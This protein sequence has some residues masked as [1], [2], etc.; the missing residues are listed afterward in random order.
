VSGGAR[1]RAFEKALSFL[2]KRDRTER[3]V[4]E[5]LAKAGFDEAAAK[6]AAGRLKDLG[7]VND[8]D[9]A[10]RF[11]E[12]LIAKGR[13]RLRISE[14]LR[15]KGLS[16]EL[17]RYTIEDGYS[18][19][20]ELEAAMSAAEKTVLEMGTAAG[21]DVQKARQKINRRLVSLGFPYAAVGEV[22]RKLR[23]KER[24]AE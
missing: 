14:E 24:T 18:R 17:V 16:E 5:R 12:V 7:Y 3:E 20:A 22:M 4:L 9:Y 19:E 1:D 8:A 23:A 15:R 13:G 6:D 21:A 2:E 10:Q 11:L